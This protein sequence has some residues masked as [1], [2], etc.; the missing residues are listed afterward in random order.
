M[1]FVGEGTFE[2]AASADKGADSNT[3]TLKAFGTLAGKDLP[4]YVLAAL[5]AR[6]PQAGGVPGPDSAA[7]AA[8]GALFP[9]LIAVLANAIQSSLIKQEQAKKA[10]AAA[11]KKSGQRDK[12]WYKEKFPGKTDEELAMIMMG[13]AMG[14]TDNPD[15]DPTSVGDNENPG[16]AGA[17]YGAGG[18]YS[19]EGDQELATAESE[20]ETGFTQ[21]QAESEKATAEK[22]LEQEQAKPPVE[23]ETMT[24][25][26]DAKG[27]EVEFVKDPATGEWVN[28]E[29]GNTYDPEIQKTAEMGWAKDKEAIDKN[30]D[31]NDNSSSEYDKKLR[32]DE[33]A[34][35]NALQL[36]N[37]QAEIMQKYGTTSKEATMDAIEESRDA[38]DALAEAYIRAGYVADVYEKGARV[39]V[40]VADATIDGMG[41]ALGPAGRVVRATYKT[42]KGVAETTA[43]QGLSW[44]NASSGFVKGGV[45]AASDFTNPKWSGKVQL[46]VKSGLQIG[47]EVVGETT[48]SQGKGFAEGL[49]K[50]VVK[51]ALDAIPDATNK[52]FGGDLIQTQ[53]KNG[54]VRVA[55][56]N[57]GKWSGKVV[58]KTVSTVFKSQKNNRQL[59]QT[60]VKALVNLTNEFQIKPMMGK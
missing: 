58:N 24:I 11:K 26:V 54:Q 31:V 37:K 45:D 43:E 1:E 15:D 46:A 49:K 17:G 50:G 2:R 59:A 18:D 4:A 16:Q 27:T 33:K 25:Q 52:G 36:A 55:V 21:E 42:V 44:Q 28:P 34:R 32:V 56:N 10:K 29:T 53:L 6:M 41:N 8:T 39:V 12:D 47:S 5:A 40:S 51:A 9:P 3:Y 22:Q 30:R 20:T 35:Q 38:S 60:G 7:Q 23:P 14:N 19:S 57:A 13:D 48:S